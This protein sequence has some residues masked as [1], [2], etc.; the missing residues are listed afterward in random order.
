MALV[1]RPRAPWGVP[2]WVDLQDLAERFFESDEESLLRVEE[3][4]DGTTLVV[5]AEAPGLDPDKDVTIS[6]ENGK[7][8]IRAQREE[9]TEHKEKDSYRSEF[10]YG[11]FNRTIALPAGATETD[12]TASYAD[13]VLEIRVPIGGELPP[14]GRKVPVTRG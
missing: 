7:L 10:R 12:V 13:G 1:R 11:S 5:R 14:G 8:T 4:V 9:R 3:Y 6:V 2:P